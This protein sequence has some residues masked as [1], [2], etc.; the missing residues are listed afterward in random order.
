PA[1]RE[2]D[3]EY[4][5]AGHDDDG[6]DARD[7]IQRSPPCALEIRVDTARHAVEPKLMHREKREVYSD[8]QQPEIPLAE[9]LAHQSA[10]D[11]G[12]PVVKR[13][14]QRKHGAAE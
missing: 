11:F 8:E 10:G 6:A 4:G 1:Q 13:A 2:I 7:E 14:Q 9:P 12:E 3:D 5:H